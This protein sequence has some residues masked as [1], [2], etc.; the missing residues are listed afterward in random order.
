MDGEMFSY[1]VV[2]GGLFVAL[3]PFSWVQCTCRPSFH[4]SSINIEHWFNT[5]HHLK[6]CKWSQTWSCSILK[7]VLSV[8]GVE[9]NLHPS[10][11]SCQHSGRRGR[12]GKKSQDQECR[13]ERMSRRFPPFPPAGLPSQLQRWFSLRKEGGLLFMIFNMFQSWILCEQI[14]FYLSPW[15]NKSRSIQ[16][17]ISTNVYY[18]S[19]F[20]CFV[21]LRL[22]LI[23]KKC[24]NQIKHFPSLC[25]R[26]G[27]AEPQPITG[28]LQTY[29][30]RREFHVIIVCSR[31]KSR[32]THRR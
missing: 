6:I 9:L 18:L 25:I 15:M 31:E 20:L 28:Q 22:L 1:R 26:K 13:C 30:Q 7:P 5:K 17:S 32:K 16:L 27:H 10:V 24:F 14:Y 19:L 23:L 3:F 11:P 4:G 8:V 12:I 29:F 21:F 2:D